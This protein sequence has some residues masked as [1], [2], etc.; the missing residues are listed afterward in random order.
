MKWNE[1]ITKWLYESHAKTYS[2]DSWT[3]TKHRLF[4][5]ISPLILLTLALYFIAYLQGH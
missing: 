3:A 2:N 4:W 1:K 5:I